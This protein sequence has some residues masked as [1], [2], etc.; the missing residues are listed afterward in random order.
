MR[1]PNNTVFVYH[2]DGQI[3]VFDLETSGLENNSLIR[4]GWEHTATLDSCAFIEYLANN[5][6]ADDVLHTLQDLFKK[7]K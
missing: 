2:K 1:N 6:E 4:N 5:K 7:I 3:K